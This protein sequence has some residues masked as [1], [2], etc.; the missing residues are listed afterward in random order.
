MRVLWTVMALILGLAL[1]MRSSG[2]SLGS[3]AKKEKERRQKNKEAGVT[4]RSLN[5]DDLVTTKGQLAGPVDSGS[6]AT[7]TASLAAGGAFT[8]GSGRSSSSDKSSSGDEASWR[9][10]ADAARARVAQAQAKYDEAMRKTALK[11]TD[12]VTRGP[13]G[14]IRSDGQ[15]L[16]IDVEENARI[17]REQAEAKSALDKAKQELENLSED[18]RH[19]GVPAGWVR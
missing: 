17:L 14:R 8:S 9:S 4:A 5:E 16:A 10:R 3:A 1:P 2:E 13:G 7:Q 19:A 11:P 6:S 12:I 15:V 18:A